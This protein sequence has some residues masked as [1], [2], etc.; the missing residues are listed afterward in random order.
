[1]NTIS[2][3]KIRQELGDILNRVSLRHDEFIV[4]RKGRQLA[5]IVPVD[6]LLAMRKAA[7]S[8]ILKVMEEN[9]GY[10]IDSELAD[11]IANEAKHRSRKR[12]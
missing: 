9:A 10:G 12:G 3:M 6:T 4:E 11:K 1:M 2:T 7:S 5:A 8:R